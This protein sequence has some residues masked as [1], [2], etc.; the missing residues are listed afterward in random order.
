MRHEVELRD[1]QPS[2]SLRQLIAA[3]GS[4]GFSCE[5]ERYWPAISQLLD[6]FV[7]LHCSVS[8][9]ARFFQLSTGALSRLLLRDE[10]VAHRINVYR[11]AS[12]LKPLR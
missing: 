11:K 1:F 9:T 5:H 7:T 6:V 10:R 12:G 4:R 2:A 3:P 8:E